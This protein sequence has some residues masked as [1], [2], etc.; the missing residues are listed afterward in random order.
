MAG[1]ALPAGFLPPAM[2]AMLP[3]F[4]SMAGMAAM[5]GTAMGGTAAA[6]GAGAGNTAGAAA[7]GS[8]RGGGGGY[9]RE[10]AAYDAYAGAYGASARAS[11][12]DSKRDEYGDA[13]RGSYAEPGRGGYSDS[14]RDAYGDAGRA[15]Y[16]D[17]GRES[18]R[19]Q[20]RHHLWGEHG[21]CARG[22]QGGEVLSYEGLSKHAAC[23]LFALLYM[24]LHKLR[25]T[26]RTA[27]AGVYLHFAHSSGRP[28]TK[29][30]HAF[31][32]C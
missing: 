19:G 24:L 25:C 11:Y 2:A 7:E 10:P 30:R 23:C 14:G 32:H 29:S 18:E 5:G 21:A 16:A 15:S 26:R 27:L 20:A 17:A 3:G 4:A 22:A 8:G 28:V 6:T 31:S 1:F 12:D 9:Q 13:G